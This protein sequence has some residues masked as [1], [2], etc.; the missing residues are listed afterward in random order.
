VTADHSAI[1]AIVLHVWGVHCAQHGCEKSDG[2][3]ER[4]RN[5]A[6]QCGGE[7]CVCIYLAGLQVWCHQGARVHACPSVMLGLWKAKSRKSGC[8]GGITGEESA[9]LVG[10]RIAETGTRVWGHGAWASR[11]ARHY[12]TGRY[13][14]VALLCCWGLLGGQHAGV[15]HAA[16]HGTQAVRVGVAGGQAALLQQPAGLPCSRLAMYKV[17]GWLW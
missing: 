3:H 1:A 10:Q 4:G 6:V 12:L 15:R 8:G 13:K 16:E 11:G 2:M 7:R 5:N 17:V 9:I 14:R